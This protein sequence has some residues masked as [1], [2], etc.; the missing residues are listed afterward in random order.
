MEFRNIPQ[1]YERSKWRGGQPLALLFAVTVVLP[2][3]TLAV[4]ASRALDSDRR[5]AEQAWR[6]RM[7]DAA[8]RAYAHLERR[9]LEIRTRADELGRGERP[10]VTATAGTI[11]VALS[12]RLELSPRSVFAWVPDGLLPRGPAVPRELEEA[13]NQEVLGNPEQAISVYKD[14]RQRMDASWRGWIHLRLARAFAVAGKTSNSTAALQIA[15]DL[16]DSPGVMPSRFAARFE[17]SSASPE[18]AALLYR[19]LNAGVW[20]LE[21]SPY[22]Y[23]EMQL[24][25]AGAPRIPAEILAAE[26][27]RQAMSR[28][29]ERVL[30]GE[31]GWLTESSVSALATRS[32]RTRA[33]ALLTPET[34]WK[35][36]LE[37]T[38]KDAP[39]DIVIRAGPDPP[40]QLHSGAALSLAPLGLP[41]SIWPEPRDPVAFARQNQNRGRLLPAVLMVVAGVLVFGSFATARLV[42]RELRIAKLQTDFTA[43]VSHEFRS[44]LTGIRQLGEMLLAGRAAGDETRQRRYYELICAESD[45]LTRLVENVLDFARMEDSRKEYRFERIETGAWLRELAG[46]AARRRGIDTYLPPELPAVEGD[47]DALS[48]AVLN[49]LDNAIKY[50]AE[51]EAVRLGARAEDGWVTIAVSDRGCGIALEDQCRIFDRFYRGSNTVGKPVRGVGLGLALVK[52]IA[53]AHGARVRVESAPGNG[54]TFCVDLKVAL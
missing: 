34:Q 24:R 25:K 41:W 1:V 43:T 26:Q 28:L 21:K 46:I 12:P 5:L 51:G 2:S 11:E 7:Q 14:L 27:T 4:L 40:S 8:R 35:Q 29:L 32:T 6:E 38:T 37:E 20:L 44:P 18:A 17:L 9:L 13:E 31:S 50:S 22:S 19:D 3:L 52:R 10:A 36:W 16:P 49:L 42:R 48:S 33:A 39:P 23:Y 30:Q 45:R 54:S 15:A 47:K 53:D